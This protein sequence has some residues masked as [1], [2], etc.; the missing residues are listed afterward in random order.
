MSVFSI[1]SF[2]PNSELAATVE[3]VYDGRLF[4]LSETSWFVTDTA[5][6]KTVTEKI[7]VDNEGGFSGVVVIGVTPSYW[8]RSTASLWDWLRAAFEAE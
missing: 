1:Q 6:V 3:R 5:T 8:G 2:R 7:G 4:K